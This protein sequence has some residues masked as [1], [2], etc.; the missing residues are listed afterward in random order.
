MSALLMVKDFDESHKFEVSNKLM[1]N[2]DLSAIVCSSL[3]RECSTKEMDPTKTN[4][5]RFMV[6]KA[7]FYA[8]S[9]S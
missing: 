9:S 5:D 4:N 8:K 2:S 3:D 6:L 1:S 7:I